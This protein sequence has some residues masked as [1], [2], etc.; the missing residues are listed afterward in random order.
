MEI[1]VTRSRIAGT[2]PHYVYRALVP[3]DKLS[4]QR[5]A[6]AGTVAGPTIAG[7]IPCVRIGPL[8]APEH[9]FEM[10]HQLRSGLPRA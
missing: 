5:R 2:L 1:I 3:A 10:A 9:Y 7:R 4:C 8:L 6:L